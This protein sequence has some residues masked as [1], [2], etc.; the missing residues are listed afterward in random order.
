MIYIQCPAEIEGNIS[1]SPYSFPFLFL[2]GGITSCP[3]W[4]PVIRW[5]QETAARQGRQVGTPT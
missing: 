1:G 4:Q 2:G 5:R 3:L